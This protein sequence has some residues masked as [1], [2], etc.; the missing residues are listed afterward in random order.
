MSGG[1]QVGLDSAA[2]NPARVY[3]DALYRQKNF[4]TGAGD[5]SGLLGQASRLLRLASMIETDPNLSGTLRIQGV[6]TLYYASSMPASP[7]IRPLTIQHDYTGGDWGDI[8]SLTRAGMTDDQMQ[9]AI[10]EWYATRWGRAY[11]F[12]I[13]A[14]TP[15]ALR[16]VALCLYQACALTGS[17]IALDL[18]H[19]GHIGVTGRSTARS[20]KLDHGFVSAGAV[21]FDLFGTGQPLEIEWMNQDGDAL[22]I[23]DRDGAATQA[24]QTDGVVS[25]R[26]LFGSA[27][28]FDNGY[29]KLANLLLEQNRLASLD[30][31]GFQVATSLK[32]KSLEGLKAW[33]D[34]N[35]DARIQPD[36]LRTLD[37]LGITEIAGLPSYTR[38]AADEQVLVAS[39]NQ[40]GK[41]HV[42][43]DVF[44]AIAPESQT[45]AHPYLPQARP[46]PATVKR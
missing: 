25:G 36:E 42:A 39:F 1:P 34:S 35:H 23:D 13:P 29:A 3:G 33:I 7:Y 45:K 16:A 41:K 12:D 40:N 46:R 19:D 27:G 32:G 21:R 28:G 20:R 43:E 15:Q 26:Q 10:Y 11:Q 38:N 24:A 17:P 8:F 22:L 5:T 14:A 37:S 4:N 18:N 44:F 31:G 30:T 9:R 6:N 2:T